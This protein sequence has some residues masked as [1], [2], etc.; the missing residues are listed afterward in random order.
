MDSPECVGGT[1]CVLLCEFVSVVGAE[2]RM[3]MWAVLLGVLMSPFLGLLVVS[4]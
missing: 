1:E 2:N 3:H 4:L